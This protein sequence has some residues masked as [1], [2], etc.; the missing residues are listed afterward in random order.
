MGGTLQENVT[1]LIPFKKGNREDW[2]REAIGSLPEGLPYL[3]AE[4]D[5]EMAE[6]L[7]EALARVETELVF[8]MNA[9]D[10]IDHQAL[11]FLHSLSW[12]ADLL[13][14]SMLLADEELRPMDYRKAPFFCPHRLEVQNYIGGVFLARTDALRGIGGWRDLEILEDWD[15]HVRLMRAGARFKAVPE[16]LFK[17]RQHSD[18]RNKVPREKLEET[19][20]RMKRQIVGEEPDLRATFYYQA[21]FPAAYY[22]CLNP[23]LHLPGHAIDQGDL[24][25]PKSEGDLI[26]FPL[27]RGAAIWQFPGDGARAIQMAHMQEQ[28]IRVL[29]ESDDSYFD[30]SPTGFSW[31][32]KLKDGQ[33]TLEGHQLILPWVDGIIVTTPH[34][35]KRY[36]KHNPNVYVCPN[37]IEPAH[38]PEPL[39]SE[40]G[41]LRIGWFAS[42]SHADDERLV[43]RAL[44]WA[45]QQPDVQILTMGFDPGWTFPRLHVPWTN[46]MGVY[47]EFMSIVDIGLA[48]VI[49]TPWAACRSDLKA[50]EY[51]ISGAWPIVSDAIPYKTYEGPCSRAR[52]PK[53]FLRALQEIVVKR[54]AIPD[55]QRAVREYVL[56]E[57]TYEK[58]AWRWEEACGSM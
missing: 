10:V 21:S 5:G 22:R 50:I 40:E 1:V 28:G 20:A 31:G 2:L 38:W 42:P 15:I 16:A 56:A 44:E 9:D 12:D 33:H 3:V 35:A 8:V 23:A 37:Q 49:E 36:G 30:R 53:D 18:S 48:P 47:R 55:M 7:N 58:N 51:G 24:V 6:A 45:S 39:K 13:Y 26:E 52:T 57:R 41:L 43:K 17:Y 54:D 19:V 27:H 25:L 34:L 32:M 29:V 14:P 46:D 11:D 4:N